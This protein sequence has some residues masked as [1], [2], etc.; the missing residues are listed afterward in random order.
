MRRW[1]LIL[2][3]LLILITAILVSG[4]SDLKSAYAANTLLSTGNQ[5]INISTT[6]GLALNGTLGYQGVSA[7]GNIV[8][9][10]SSATNLPNAGTS[11][12]GLYAYNIKTDS[13]NRIDKSSTG[14]GANDT[15][16]TT[17][18]KS[19]RVSET[20]RYITY[21]SKATNL[22][23][24]VVAPANSFAIYKHDTQT[25]VT[26]QLSGNSSISGF[27]QNYDRNL[28][29]SNDGRFVLLASRYIVSNFPY[30]YAVSLGD[31]ASGITSWSAIS[32][33]GTIEGGSASDNTRGSMSCDGV[34]IAH[35][36]SNQIHLVDNRK[37]SNL[38]ID[39]TGVKSTGPIISC[40]GRYILYATTNRTDITPTPSGM[41]SNMHLVRYDR[42]TGERM[43]VDSDST[44]AFSSG[45]GWGGPPTEP[46]ENPFNA[47][48]SD[49]GDVVFRYGNGGSMY[50][51][52]LS[53][54]SGT[55]ESV[56][57]NVSGS[58]VNSSNGEITRDG[59]YVFFI[60][61]PYTL[62]LSAT[63]GNQQI[64]RA[65]TNL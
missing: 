15:L 13:T 19:V 46:S 18:G 48:I 6:D 21:I 44:S 41:N 60:M 56:A 4:I 27:P 20:G 53:D 8:V 23:D 33:G 35:N 51:K 11:T 36:K 45:F 37:G 17:N 49:T 57:M 62:G 9:F 5:V 59:K 54:G 12:Y 43:Y 7:D 16:F 24:G 40:N 52:H 28:A 42:L 47:S 30:Y 63:S 58:Y 14:I 29:I 10:T 3:F 38:L 1:Y 34:F 31:E 39:Q 2:A 25:G 50:L 65:K 55:L 32:Y 61:D 64:I 22:I 26:T